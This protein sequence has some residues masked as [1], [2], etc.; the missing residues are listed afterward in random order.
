MTLTRQCG[1]CGQPASFLQ[2]GVP[3]GKWHACITCADGSSGW[4][5]EIAGSVEITTLPT[6][7]HLYVITTGGTP[8]SERMNAME[9]LTVNSHV[10]GA[11]ADGASGTIGVVDAYLVNDGRIYTFIDGE[12]LPAVVSV[13]ARE[14]GQ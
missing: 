8:E 1:Q 2:P 14:A 7:M 10:A 3:S 4:G 6:G 5:I 12:A 9:G 11:M 13:W